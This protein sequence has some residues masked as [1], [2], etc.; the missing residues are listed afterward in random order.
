MYGRGDARQHTFA[1][2]MLADRRALLQLGDYS[3]RRM[4]INR[5]NIDW[6]VRQ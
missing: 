1:G 2:L 4:E 6:A 5:F 3:E